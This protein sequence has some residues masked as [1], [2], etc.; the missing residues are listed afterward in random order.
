MPGF[1]K[2]D[3]NVSINDDFLTIQAE[4]TS[5]AP[6]GRPYL[7]ERSFARVQRT[8]RLPSTVDPDSVDAKL[9]NGVL[10]ME[11]KK[12]ETERTRRIEVK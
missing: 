6:K 2:D 4:R 8:L 11:M 12:S 1:G 10:H 7:N 3:I 5:E 9:E